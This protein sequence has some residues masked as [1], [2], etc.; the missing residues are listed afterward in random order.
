MQQPV[1]ELIRQLRRQRS[2]TQTEL[3]G[4]R[5]SKS[6][7][8]AVEREKIIPSV[9]ALHFFAEQFGQ[10][11][12]YL[13][14]LKQETE[15]RERHFPALQTSSCN[16]IEIQEEFSNLLDILLEGAEQHT[17]S[18]AHDLPMLSPEMIATLPLQ[19]QARYSFLT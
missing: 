6:Y 12:D 8:S 14:Q 19:R 1:G 11:S 13:V 5:F 16:H 9:E 2:L 17:F 3:G 7:V 10:S 15:S 18:P 4:T